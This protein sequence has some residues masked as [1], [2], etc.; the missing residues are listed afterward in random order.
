[1]HS[2]RM[3]TA[4]S[5]PYP[6]PRTE[7]PLG[8]RSRLGRDPLGQMDRDRQTPVKTLPCPKFRFRKMTGGACVIWA[9][10]FAPAQVEYHYQFT[11]PLGQVQVN[12]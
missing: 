5:L 12:P 3:R 10:F 8:Q 11:H 2:S 7:T 6:P 4:R 9:W 1:M